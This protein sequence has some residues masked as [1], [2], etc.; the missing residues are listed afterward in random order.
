MEDIRVMEKLLRSLTSKFE[1]VMAAIEESKNLE[2]ISIEE[3]L[4]S[5]QVHEQSM[6]KK[7][8]F[9]IFEQAL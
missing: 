9:I 7:T 6:Q 5:L 3:L 4:G 1:H 8:G 2:E